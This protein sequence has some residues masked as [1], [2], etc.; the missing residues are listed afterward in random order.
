[1]KKKHVLE[2]WCATTIALLLLGVLGYL[3][4][5]REY[6]PP[7]EATL[8][9]RVL[10]K[11]VDEV[12]V[13]KSGLCPDDACMQTRKEPL[14]VLRG[15]EARKLVNAID[16][17]E[18]PSSVTIFNVGHPGNRGFRF[19]ARG[20]IVCNMNYLTKT[21]NFYD[22]DFYPPASFDTGFAKI[23]MKEYFYHVLQSHNELSQ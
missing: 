3:H 23:T 5:R 9:V 2:F 12:R 20:K 17:Y 4:W 22:T 16:Y 11:N 18:R 21:Q 8:Q 15:S 6:G 14:C 7:T 1:M 19:F 13:Y 10:L